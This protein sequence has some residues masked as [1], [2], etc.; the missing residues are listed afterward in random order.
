EDYIL[1]T[2]CMT[3]TIPTYPTFDSIFAFDTEVFSNIATTFELSN[4]TSVPVSPGLTFYPNT[5]TVTANGTLTDLELTI[6]GSPQASPGTY[7]LILSKNGVDGSPI[8]FTE[9]SV[10]E[11]FFHATISVAVTV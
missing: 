4:V 3:L 11:F 1:A 8:S 6:V 7:N 10:S 5:F 9:T 2:S